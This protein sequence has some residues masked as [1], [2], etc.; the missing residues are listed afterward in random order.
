VRT[1]TREYREL[2]RQLR[3]RDWKGKGYLTFLISLSALLAITSIAFS[4]PFSWG[5]LVVILVAILYSNFVEYSLHR[6][7]LHYPFFLRGAYRIHTGVHHRFFTDKHM[8]YEEERDLF[9]ILTPF[10]NTLIIYALAGIAALSFGMMSALNL[11]LLFFGVCLVYYILFELVHLGSHMSPKHWCHR[12]PLLSRGMR[13]H[14]E[15]HDPKKMRLIN[16]NI[17][18]PVFDILFRT[19]G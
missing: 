8:D 12:I 15:H 1:R 19:M 10:S 7:V 14:R 13:L 18:V 11:G 16:F 3:S 6:W 5:H 17:V 2:H 9:D 4:G